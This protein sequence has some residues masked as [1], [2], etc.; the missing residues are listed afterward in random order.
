M[1]GTAAMLIVA[2]GAALADGSH[3]LIAPR[4]LPFLGL[5]A[6]KLI[7][8][9][10]RAPE[11]TRG[12][13]VRV[14]AERN[15]GS[16]FRTV[17][18]L[19]RWRILKRLEVV[20]VRAVVDVHLGLELAT[21][22]LAVLPTPGV[23]FVPMEA[24]ERVP[25]VTL[26]AATRGIRDPVADLMATD[27]PAAAFG[28]RKLARLST[29]AAPAGARWSRTLAPCRRSCLLGGHR[30]LILTRGG[31]CFPGRR[32]VRNS[33]RRAIVH[34]SEERDPIAPLRRN[35]I[36]KRKPGHHCGLPGF[37]Q[38]NASVA[39]LSITIFF[40]STKEPAMIL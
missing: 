40:V 31:L 36:P 29:K 34:K 28:P 22:L 39:Y 33:R 25:F 27:Q 6:S 35:G 17:R 1:A 15:H 7:V 26:V 21:A 19:E 18:R 2:W 37:R 8:T 38:D 30:P 23:P 32:R 13:R 5:P 11:L 9:A 3:S 16:A 10:E 4:W 14:P 20:L 24:A 12:P